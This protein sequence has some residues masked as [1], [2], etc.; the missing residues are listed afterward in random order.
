[1]DHASIPATFSVSRGWTGE[2]IPNAKATF[3][4]EAGTIAIED[5]VV[6][7]SGKRR[8][9]DVVDATFES[10]GLKLNGRLV[11]PKGQGAV[12]IAALVH[13]SEADSA[14]LFNRLQYVL[15]ASGI[16]AFVFD[17]R[18]TGKSEGTYTQDFELLADDAAAAL[19]KAKEIA[20]ARAGEMGFVGGSQAGWIEPLAAGKVKTDF[21]LVGFG[22]AE[23]PLAEDREE[24]F[25]DLRSAGYGEDVIV[26]AREITDAT[27][28]VVA[29]HFKEGYDELDAVRAKYSHEPWYEKAQ[30]EYTGSLLA[31]PNWATQIAGPWYE[32]GTPMAYDPLPAL[33]AYQGPHLW[34]LAGKDSSAP[35]ANTLRILRDVQSTHPNFDVVMFPNA[36]HGMT[37]FTE[38]DGARLETHFSNGYFQLMVDWLKTKRAAVSVEGPVVYEGAEPPQAAPAS[39]AEN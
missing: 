32:V 19:R 14:V 34:I 35:S 8:A 10:H 38:K 16:G 18:G 39:A 26:K 22:L 17:K 37:E 36:D 3:D 29:S 6:R 12:P 33:N 5:D 9:F 1:M 13:G 27:G 24:V 31:Y 2:K 23:S 7:A 11:L 30:G 15:P 4:C 28:K 21:V 20:G 25:D